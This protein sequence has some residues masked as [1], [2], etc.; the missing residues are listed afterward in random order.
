MTSVRL[1]VY[2]AVCNV[3]GDVE[4]CTWAACVQRLARCISACAQPFIQ[5]T[6]K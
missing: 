2:P 3:G 5:T 6:S 4:I 1:S